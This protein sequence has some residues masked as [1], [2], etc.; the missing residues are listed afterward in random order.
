MALRHVH[1]SPSED[2]P[3]CPET[4]AIRATWLHNHS[5]SDRF[6]L[7]IRNRDAL[8]SLFAPQPGQPTLR[9]TLSSYR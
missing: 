7:F 6:N 8:L 4:T 1:P 9:T 2:A 3:D 5:T